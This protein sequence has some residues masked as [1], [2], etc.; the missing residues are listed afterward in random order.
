MKRKKK[1]TGQVIC[2]WCEDSFWFLTK[3]VPAQTR[4]RTHRNP[5]CLFA[6]FEVNG[7]SSRSKTWLSKELQENSHPSGE[8][9][10]ICLFLPS[11]SPSRVVASL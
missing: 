6:S 2:S 5:V 10:G 9:P 4:F 7:N 11:E 1:E 3:P 8:S